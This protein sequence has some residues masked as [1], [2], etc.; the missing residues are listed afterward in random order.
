MIMSKRALLIGVNNYGEGFDSLQAPHKDVMALANVLKQPEIGAFDLVQPL[1]DPTPQDM[2]GAIRDFCKTSSKDDLVLIYFSGHGVI[3]DFTGDQFFLGTKSAAYDANRKLYKTTVVSTDLIYELIDLCPCQ[4]QIIILDC[5]HGGAFGDSLISKDNIKKTLEK[6]G[7]RERVIL[8]SCTPIQN[9]YEQPD[10]ELSLYTHHLVAGLKTG[11]ADFD[12]DGQITVE[13]LH[14]YVQNQLRAEAKM[15]PEILSLQPQAVKFVLAQT[16]FGNKFTDE[17]LA[18]QQRLAAYLRNK[19]AEHPLH[20]ELEIE[21][22]VAATI[23]TRVGKE[24]QQQSQLKDAIRLYRMSLQ[25]NP[26]DIVAR[27]LLGDVLCWQ[28]KW[29]EAQTYYQQII[30]RQP[31]DSALALAYWGLGN[32]ESNQNNLDT[33]FTAYRQANYLDPSLAGV[34]I[35]WGIT[36]YYQGKF[37][38]ALEKLQM[39]I[40]IDEYNPRSHHFLGII[41]S[42]LGQLSATTLAAEHAS[43]LWE[44]AINANPY[45]SSAYGLLA[46]A[47]TQQLK[48]KEAEEAARKAIKL[49]SYNAEAHNALGNVLVNQKKLDAAIEAYQDAIRCHPFLVIIHINVGRALSFRG[50]LD[51]ALAKFQHSLTLNPYFFDTH[52][53]IGDVFYAQ[54]KFTAAVQPYKKAIK[55]NRHD[56]ISLYQLACVLRL[57]GQHAE[58]RAENSIAIMTCEQLLA[59]DPKDIAAL[60]GLA[61]ALQA[62]GRLS[63]AVSLYLRISEIN[64]NSPFIHGHLGFALL[65]NGEFERARAR[66]ELAILKNDEDAMAFYGLGEVFRY[67]KQIQSAMDKYQ[68]SIFLNPKLAQSY[69]AIGGILFEQNQITKAGE[70]YQQALDLHP[71]EAWNHRNLGMVFGVQGYLD[72]AIEKIS[73]AISLNP[74]EAFFYNDLANMHV[75]KGEVNIAIQKYQIAIELQPN[76]PL[77]YWNLGCGLD[78]LGDLFSAVYEFRMAVRLDKMNQT[79]ASTLNN[80]LQR[81]KKK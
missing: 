46:N 58:A 57:S 73:H 5:C 37:E 17:Q 36:L 51:G 42:A 66:F 14:Q 65:Q 7:K 55:I 4:Q 34:Y 80:A 68:K 10:R 19:N 25:L 12:R 59:K 61:Q 27:Q 77:L 32:T 16:I 60:Y 41:L 76:N 3:D 50:D 38:I 9:S 45:N 2:E 72:T 75:R 81:L 20:L 28:N 79:F 64:D 48:F 74:N 26:E 15:L 6:G 67:Q 30:D 49:N 29:A 54:G 62:E 8:A 44:E 13:D 22:R 53:L 33:A 1:L 78:S 56:F 21:D 18:S 70:Y 69:A 39:S 31:N 23:Y 43:K 52:R 71:H 63:E 35:D 24:Y 40:H 11:A 47:L